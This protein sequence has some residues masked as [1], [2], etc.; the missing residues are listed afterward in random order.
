MAANNKL[1]HWVNPSAI[2]SI[3][4]K[5]EPLDNNKRRKVNQLNRNRKSKQ[6]ITIIN[7]WVNNVDDD[8][9]DMAY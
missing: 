3:G 9:D 7:G 6:K 4:F 5:A 2:T 8:N 1:M